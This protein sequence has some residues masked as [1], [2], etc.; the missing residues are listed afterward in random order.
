MSKY[1]FHLVEMI[2]L[3]KYVQLVED[4]LGTLIFPVTLNKMFGGGQRIY[5]VD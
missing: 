4:W 2:M 3:F 5:M 1:R